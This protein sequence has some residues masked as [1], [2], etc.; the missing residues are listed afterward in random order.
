MDTGIIF[1]VVVVV[2]ILFVKVH[3][4]DSR[5][6]R[7]FSLFNCNKTVLFVILWLHFCLIYHN[8]VCTLSSVF[9]A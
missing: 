4:G 8:C 3:M 9:T 6:C 5:V 2:F 1:V 7:F